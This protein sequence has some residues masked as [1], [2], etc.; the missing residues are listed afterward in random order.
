[1]KVNAD[2]N[3]AVVLRPTDREWIHSPQAGVD[4][5]MLDR[6]G[7]EVARATSIVRYL[8]GSDF[9]PHRH[10][11]GEEFLVLDGV[12]ADGHGRYPTGTY[13]RNPPG[14]AHRPDV[15]DGCTIFVKLRQFDPD[16]LTPITIN[17]GASM[18]GAPVRAKGRQS[19]PLH[20]FRSETVTVE[21][22][23]P[24]EELQQDLPGGA[25]LLILQGTLL[26]DGET[27]PAHSWIR[28]PA[29]GKLSVN[30]GRDGTRF[31]MK[32]G[33]LPPSEAVQGNL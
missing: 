17:V 1:M 2:F 19:L 6:I 12:F 13:V 11:L 25:E 22:L 21:Q 31:W 10:D 23:G 15:P 5:Q 9:K 4:R 7:D 27:L 26:H 20:D 32:T 14:S 18:A 28:L 29:G 24:A 33:H 8:P 30:G 3:R 16:D